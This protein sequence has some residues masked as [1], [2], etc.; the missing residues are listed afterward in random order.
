MTHFKH[1]KFDIL[2]NSD[3]FGL[4][5]LI[6]DVHNGRKKNVLQIQ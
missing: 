4:F 3:V 6:L 2:L 5:L 1:S